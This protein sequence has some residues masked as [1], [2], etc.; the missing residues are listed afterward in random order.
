MGPSEL[1][2]QILS[3]AR[4]YRTHYYKRRPLNFASGAIARRHLLNTLQYVRREA[5]QVIDNHFREKARDQ[6]RDQKR[7]R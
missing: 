1:R 4:Y 6:Q 5:Q 7:N 3:A 2:D